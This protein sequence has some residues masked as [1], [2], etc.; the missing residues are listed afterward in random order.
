MSKRLSIL[1]L[2]VVAASALT[3]GAALA[4]PATVHA[5]KSKTVT[6]AMHDPGC[7][8]F[9]D[10]GKLYA[11]ASVQRGTTFRNLDEATVI[12]K[13]TGFTKRV[14]VGKT[15]RLSKAGTYH[16]TMVKQHPDDNHLLLIVK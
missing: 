8:W 9:S 1:F 14:A 7:H 11:A 10:G 6:I 2:A 13:G 16:V 5:I 12:F 15:L 4:S 3:V